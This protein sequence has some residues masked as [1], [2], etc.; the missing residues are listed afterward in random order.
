M[1]RPSRARIREWFRI[2]YRLEVE[3]FEESGTWRVSASYP[4]LPGLNSIADTLVAAVDEL[5]IRRVRAAVQ[6]MI[7]GDEPPRPR[8]PLPYPVCFGTSSVEELIGDCC[9]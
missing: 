5:E 1:T 6:W 8:P 3:A 7:T 9:D 4:E 2:P